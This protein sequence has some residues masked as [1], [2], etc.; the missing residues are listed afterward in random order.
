MDEPSPFFLIP[1]SEPRCPDTVEKTTEVSFC[2]LESNK[3]PLDVLMFPFTSL[4]RESA[5]S[6]DDVDKMTELIHMF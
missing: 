3:L 1:I 6:P 4:T 2:T 5:T